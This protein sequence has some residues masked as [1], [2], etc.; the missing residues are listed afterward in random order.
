[1]TIPIPPR[2]DMIDLSEAQDPRYIDWPRVAVQV[3]VGVYC[4]AGEGTAID[5]AC[6]G[7]MAGAR[8]I[9]RPRGVYWFWRPAVDPERQ[10]ELLAAAHHQHD[11]DLA[12]WVDCEAGD[13]LAADELAS[14]LMRLLL[15]LDACLPT[16]VRGGIYTGPGWWSARFK[17]DTGWAFR[18]RMLVVAQYGAT[19]PDVPWPW[20]EF[21][22]W[23]CAGN[24][25]WSD[26]SWG[27]RP[28]DAGAHMVA[29]PGL[30]DGVVDAHGRPAEVDTDVVG[31]C[32][33]TDL[34]A[35]A[36]PASELDLSA[37][38]DRQRALRRLGYDPGALD[39]AW[40]P[41]SRAALVLAQRHLGID[42]T[43][44]WTPD[45]TTALVDSARR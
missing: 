19:S 14:C 20:D 28:K 4:K 41:R 17:G 18:S 9:A 33:L 39:G 15:R 38:R 27:P 24:T 32:A 35:G 6:A 10:A 21:A 29:H 22:V 31:N 3:A 40:G 25:I 16:G 8:A 44:V 30:V 23:Q 45:M 13:G 42:I 43:G 2:P 11:A 1:M 26:G 34:E 37:P 7:H 5:R 36:Q 12:P